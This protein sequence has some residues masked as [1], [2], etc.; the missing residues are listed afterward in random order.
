MHSQNNSLP[1]CPAGWLDL[2]EGYSFL[3]NRG[4]GAEGSGQNLLSPGSCIEQFSATP[5]I[6]CKNG[7]CNKYFSKFSFWLGNVGEKDQF[8][9]VRFTSYKAGSTEIREAIS[10]CRVCT[11]RESIRDSYSN[12]RIRGL[13]Y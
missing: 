6:E 8:S 12:Y 9:S 4:E 2:W 3:M 7:N 13:H 1:S 11:L 5:F 10:R